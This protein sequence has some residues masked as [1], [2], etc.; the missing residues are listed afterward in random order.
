MAVRSTTRAA[1]TRW[2]RTSA[3]LCAALFALGALVAGC[4]DDDDD[5]KSPM[6]PVDEGPFRRTPEELLQD[7]FETAYSTRDSALYAEMLCEDFQFQFLA[8]DADSLRDI[9]GGDN[10]WGRTLELRNAGRLFRSD[11]VTSILL[12]IQIHSKIAYGGDDCIGCQQMETTVTLRV[13]TIGDGTEPLIYTVDSPQTFVAKPD[14]ADSALWCLF[15]QIDRPR[16]LAKREALTE[17]TPFDKDTPATVQTTWG[18]IKG[19]FSP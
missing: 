18:R 12:N 10:F 15:R 1:A 2:W 19:I 17:T 13:T 3:I 4:G 11:S 5:D 16:S 9:L 14:P 6:D 7:F 8:Q